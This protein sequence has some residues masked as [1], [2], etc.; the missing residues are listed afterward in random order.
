MN[1]RNNES[2]KDGTRETER[3]NERKTR[4]KYEIRK[5][6]IKR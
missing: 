2:K 5:N 1:E 4:T 6:G 3:T